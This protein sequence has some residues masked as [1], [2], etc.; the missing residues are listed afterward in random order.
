MNEEITNLVL[1][2]HMQAMKYELGQQVK[3]LGQQVA[4]L[5]QDTQREFEKVHYKLEDIRLHCEALEVDLNATILMVGK[6][7]KKLAKL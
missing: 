4:T 5:R 3:N 6:H 2:Q 7:Q 1:L